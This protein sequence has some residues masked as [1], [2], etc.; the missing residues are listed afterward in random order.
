MRR[1]AE[2]SGYVSHEWLQVPD[3]VKLPS[4]GAN[5]ELPVEGHHYFRPQISLTPTTTMN[6]MVKTTYMIS[7]FNKMYMII[8]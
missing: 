1:E 8:R 2:A 4:V 7:L 5:M 3:S 6:T